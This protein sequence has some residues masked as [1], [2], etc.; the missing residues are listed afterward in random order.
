VRIFITGI[1]AYAGY[2]A[3]LRLTALGHEVT[4]LVRNP[5]Q[6]RLHQLRAHEVTLVTGDVGLPD[7]YRDALERSD[8]I[9]HTMLDK[10]APLA[11]DRALFGA[12]AALPQRAGR[13]FIYSTGCSIFGKI[14]GPIDEQS[15]PNPAHKL[16][17]R[18]GLEKEALELPCSVVVVRPGFMYGNDGYNSVASDWFAAAG[19]G[20]YEFRGDRT[21][22]WSW[23]HIDDLAEAYRLV[24]E[25]DALGHEIFCLGDDEQPLSVDVMKRCLE[26]A[27]Y[28]GEI[29]FGPPKEGENISTWF[30]QN[31]VMTSAKARRVLGWTVRHPSVL[32][33]LPSFYAS[34]QAA[35][36]LGYLATATR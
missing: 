15:E 8:V 2:H 19:K 1:G 32:A 9:I 21:K 17:F 13:R 14:P 33:G 3:A 12:V 10:K 27:G 6:P 30:D 16:A 5:D 4:G 24:V 29:S 36:R 20:D 31:E 34:W 28:R 23:I 22:R 35:Q 25:N 18:R 26:I 7:G 11:T